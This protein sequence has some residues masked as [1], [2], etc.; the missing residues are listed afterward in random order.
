M[1]EELQRTLEGTEAALDR[2]R[3]ETRA[4]DDEKL[5]LDKAIAKVFRETSEV[6]AATL[7]SLSEQ[8]TAEKSAQKTAADTV[9]LRKRVYEEEISVVQ[10]QNELAKLQVC[11]FGGL[12]ALGY[13]RIGG[14][15]GALPSRRHVLPWKAPEAQKQE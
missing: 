9:R 7:S 6:D 15:G 4:L 3:A 12:R 14:K 1:Y 13:C 11:V 2:A 10:L 5:G 8:T